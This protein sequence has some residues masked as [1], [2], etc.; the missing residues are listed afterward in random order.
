MNISSMLPKRVLFLISL[1][2]EFENDKEEIDQC[3]TEL[4][5]LGVD[6]RE[7]ICQENLAIA[8]GYNV[9]IVV[10]HYDDDADM[11]ILANGTLPIKAFVSY[12]P[13]DFSGLID[14]CSCNSAVAFQAI[15]NRCPSCLA[16]VSLR[17][18]PL[19]RRIIIYPSII[20]WFLED[21]ATDYDTAFDIMSKQYDEILGEI[22]DGRDTEP[23]M[24]H[25]GEK[26][27]SIYAPLKVAKKSVTPIQIF[28]HSEHE[29]KQISEEAYPNTSVHIKA[30][31]LRNVEI[32]DVVTVKLSFF[33]FD[34]QH[35]HI[36]GDDTAVVVISDKRQEIRFFIVVCEEFSAS[37]F[38]CYVD[39]LK[40]AQKINRYPFFFQVTGGESSDIIEIK[41][42]WMGPKALL[43]FEKALASGWM[44]KNEDGYH[45]VGFGIRKKDG[46]YKSR[47]RQL[48]YL[49]KQAF[50]LDKMPTP[51]A[52]IEEFFQEKQL[53]R[54]SYNVDGINQEN[55]P[56]I[57]EIDALISQIKAL[58][59]G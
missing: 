59:R 56:W 55:V 13:E 19:L 43:A 41:Q 47:T 27:T 3:L 50:I 4:R 16:K 38:G 32:G 15:K 7:H 20:E 29:N 21:E 9:V 12:L 18:V 37:N 57:K 44:I 49:C 6:V 31:D 30:Q 8:N 52:Y 36:F 23:V 33:G 5:E 28:L 45:W 42:P 26:Q 2:V 34:I 1:P 48:S 17:P 22:S 58:N 10:A 24:T 25:L 46:K 51:W 40:E 54:D 11:L 14:F 39:I 35:L 53:R